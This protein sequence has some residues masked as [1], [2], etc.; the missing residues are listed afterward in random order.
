MAEKI[1]L[2]D[3]EV[4]FLSSLSERLEIRG[5]DVNSASSAELAVQALDDNDYDAIVLDLQMPDMNGID[6]L[7]V[8]KQSHPEAQ[9]ILLSGQAT[10]EAG[11]E[12]MKLG[13]MDFMEKPADI[14]SLTEKIKKAQ[15]KKMV[16]VEKKTVD[17]VEEI[18]SHKGW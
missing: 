7:K 17:K 11:I 9:V 14:D 8:I 15:A 4:E 12:A 2:I 6:L 5:M 10:L 3:D 13:A 1:L 16:I 18:L